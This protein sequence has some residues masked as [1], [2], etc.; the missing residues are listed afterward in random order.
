MSLTLLVVG[1]GPLAKD[2]PWE[3][4][5]LGVAEHVHWLGARED[6]PQLLAAMDVLVLCSRTEGL[7]LAPIEAMAAGRPVVVT[8]V[9]GCAEI[10]ADT[11]P[12]PAT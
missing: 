1:D 2:L 9:G 10:V 5:R 4:Q 7:P 11:P 6:V 8:D 12:P 3:A